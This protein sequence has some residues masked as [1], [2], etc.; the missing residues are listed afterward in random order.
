[1][2]SAK[3]AAARQNAPILVVMHNNFGGDNS[4]QDC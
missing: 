2:E 3:S 4:R 1:M